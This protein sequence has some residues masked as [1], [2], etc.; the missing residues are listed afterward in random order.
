MPANIHDLA[1]RLKLHMEVM[2][3]RDKQCTNP[4]GSDL[5]KCL[6]IV[7]L[8]DEAGVEYFADLKEIFLPRGD[9]NGVEDDGDEAPTAPKFPRPRIV[10]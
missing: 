7:E 9:C 10:N 4:L 8:L 2:Q 1:V 5:A 3:H 6:S